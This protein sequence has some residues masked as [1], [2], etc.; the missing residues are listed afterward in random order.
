MKERAP[1]NRTLVVLDSEKSAL[2]AQTLSI[3]ATC[4]KEELINQVVHADLFDCAQHLPKDF[5]DLLIIDPPY[6]LSK[7]YGAS[8]FAKKSSE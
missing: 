1:R 8:K 5:V 2:M 7:T 4:T 6:N 3:A